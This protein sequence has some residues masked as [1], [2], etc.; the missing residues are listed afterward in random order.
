[1]IEWKLPPAPV[2]IS[3]TRSATW[4]GIGQVELDAIEPNTLQTMC[5]D[6]IKNIFEEN[7]ANNLYLQ[8]QNEAIQFRSVL[9]DFVSTL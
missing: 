4:T 8:E 1:V 5:R 6:A 9:K 3:D 7:V 2:K